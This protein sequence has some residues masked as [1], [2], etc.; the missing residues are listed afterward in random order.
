[1]PCNEHKKPL[2][3]CKCIHYCHIL[4]RRQSKS[5]CT[6]KITAAAD[7][8]PLS[9]A[10]PIV[11]DLHQLLGFFLG[12]GGRNS[13]GASN[14]LARLFWPK[15]TNWRSHHGVGSMVSDSP[16]SWKWLGGTW[17]DPWKRKVVRNFKWFVL[18]EIIN[19]FFFLESPAYLFFFFFKK[20]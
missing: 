18:F 6:R 2:Q 8:S 12:G 20:F 19:D 4:E 15:I 7:P 3:Q 14:P 10:P 17:F 9:L 13:I 11:Q 5:N 1:M 16:M